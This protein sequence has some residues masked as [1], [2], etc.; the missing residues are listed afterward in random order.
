[1]GKWSPLHYETK[2]SV[3]AE[4]CDAQGMREKIEDFPEQIRK[5]WEEG[6]KADRGRIS[7]PSHIV[8]CGMGGSAIAGDLLHDLF[9][10]DL[11]IP[12]IV[13]R[14]YDIPSFIDERSLLLISSYSGNTEET[15][16]AFSQ[17]HQKK[18]M[19]AVFTSDGEIG[20]K[21]E[22][23][24]IPTLTFPSGYPPRSALGFSFFSMVGFLTQIVSLPLD[25]RHINALIALLNRLKDLLKHPKGEIAQLSDTLIGNIPLIHI[26]R[27]LRSVALRWQTQINE[28]SKTFAHINEIPEAN[29]NEIVGLN[30]P[31]ALVRKMV[32]IFLRAKKY[33][34][35]QIGNRFEISKEIVR[36]SVKKI[37]QIEAE[38]DDKLQEM[39]SLIYKGDFL[40]Y[41]LSQRLGV[42]PTPVSRID[43][44]KQKLQE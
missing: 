41:H 15:L 38:G 18:A 23:E 42:D 24:R 9:F 19:I 39:F 10:E 3:M 40:S 14:G 44:L 5:S 36:S 35:T 25:D 11:S 13:N 27:R 30:F 1:L 32:L 7:D 12:L 17:G 16:H 22:D 2:G 34:N 8:I 37:V 29:H 31:K 4:R 33:E 43:T 20:K 28:N 26:S 21:A 6:K